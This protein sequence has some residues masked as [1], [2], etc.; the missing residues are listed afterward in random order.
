M[1]ELIKCPYRQAFEDIW[2]KY[3][4]RSL[5]SESAEF[6]REIGMKHGLIIERVG[7]WDSDARIMEEWGL[8]DGDPIYYVY[9]P[10]A[11]DTSAVELVRELVKALDMPMAI[12]Q[13]SLETHLGNKCGKSMRKAKTK[14]EQWLKKVGE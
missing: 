5:D 12:M 13:D 6:L 2:E 3:C 1:S 7:L 10:A 4:D 9:K 14:A 11:F 8:E